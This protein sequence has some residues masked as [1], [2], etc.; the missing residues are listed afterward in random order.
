M[1]RHCRAIL[2][3]LAKN[4]TD[5]TM[6]DTS[7][8][9]SSSDSVF[10]IPINYRL[11][12]F[13]GKGD[14]G[15]VAKCIR[16]DTGEAVALKIS[17][18][19]YTAAQEAS[20]LQYLME[21]N[22]DQ[23][24]IVKF[25]DW[26]QIK[27]TTSLVF[28]LLDVNLSQYMAEHS[29]NRLPLKDIRFIIKE[30]ATALS[31]LR[32]AGVIHSDIKPKNIML[33]KDQKQLVGVKLI[34]FGLAFHTREAV[35]GGYYQIPYYRAPEIILGLP[36]TEAIDLWSLGVVM[37]QMMFGSLIFPWFVE[38]SQ[39]KTICEILGQPADH[40]LDAGLKTKDFFIKNSSDQWMMTTY[41]Q[42]SNKISIGKKRYPFS[43]LDDLKMLSKEMVS[44]EEAQEWMQAVELLKAI[45]QVDA[46]KRI[47]PTGVLNHPFITQSYISETLQPVANEPS[48]R[49]AWPD[50]MRAETAIGADCSTQDC[51]GD[52]NTTSEY[53][54]ETLMLDPKHVAL[55]DTTKEIQTI[56]TTELDQTTT[57]FLRGLS[58]LR[59]ICSC[60]GSAKVWPEPQ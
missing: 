48:T 4:K 26:D 49:Q 24:N 36:F 30:L 27:N 9:S 51:Q 39:M 57:E 25:Y 46:N 8:S 47:T 14:Y 28:E 21:K 20:I 32:S 55:P 3:S 11:V 37:G 44:D 56:T 7:S 31:A 13:V 29:E 40:L 59:K 58:W 38:Y 42:Y 6:E 12:D 45:F 53:S 22:L 18:Y 35:V 2:G 41:D 10:T 52:R 15:L 1:Q 5:S 43:S 50:I 17:R 34:D 33:A 16:S 23:N 60:C 19:S 54:I